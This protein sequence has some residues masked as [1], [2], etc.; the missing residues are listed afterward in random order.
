MSLSLG[1]R[2]FF[3]SLKCEITVTSLPQHW[4]DVLHT[5][6]RWETDAELGGS[7]SK[8][9]VFIHVEDDKCL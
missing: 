3:E 2:R 9:N 1:H 7:E 4:N 6:S 8:L 5:S